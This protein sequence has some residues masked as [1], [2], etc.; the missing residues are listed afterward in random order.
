MASR[1]AASTS[2]LRIRR[3]IALFFSLKKISFFR[4]RHARRSDTRSL[5]SGWA[6]KNAA[7]HSCSSLCGHSRARLRSM[8]A[9]LRLLSRSF[10]AFSL[11]AIFCHLVSMPRTR[12]VP[13]MAI[14]MITQGIITGES[15]MNTGMNCSPMDESLLITYARRVRSTYARRP[16]RP[17]RRQR[18]HRCMMSLS[19]LHPLAAARRPPPAKI[20]K[21]MTAS[22]LHPL[23]ALLRL[24]RPRRQRHHPLLGGCASFS[25]LSARHAPHPN[26][27]AQ[28]S[29]G[30]PEREWKGSQ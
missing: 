24:R 30:F 13:S 5:M 3:A 16:C 22:S 15:R 9:N 11:R 8:M 28:R 21:I 4:W 27:L 12:H 20:L 26:A 7:T 2:T 17:R 6:S 18:H 19:P 14:S 23:V 25:E 10:S 1:E 29:R